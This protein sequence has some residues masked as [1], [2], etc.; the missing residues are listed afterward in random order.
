MSPAGNNIVQIRSSRQ[1]LTNKLL[2]NPIR[3]TPFLRRTL[4]G[5]V[6]YGCA[7]AVATA[8]NGLQ[9]TGFG[10]ESQ[11]MGGADAAVARDSLAGNTNPAGLQHTDQQALDV[12]LSPFVS[13][14]TRHQDALGN[15]DTISNPAGFLGGI[16]YAQRL[17]PQFVTGAGI[18]V[19]GGTG[20]TYKDLDTGFGTTDELSAQFAV[21]KLATAAA[22]RA[23]ERL[24]LGV[25]LGFSYGQARQ[26]VFP[27]TSNKDVPFFG[28]RLDGTSAF[29]IN[30]KLGM[31]YR[32]SPALT[33]GLVY[34]SKSPMKLEHGTLDA[35][36]TDAGLGIVRY[37]EA[38][39]DGLAF[40]QQVEAGVA[41]CPASAWLISLE[42][43]WI[44]W[45][46]SMKSVRLE[47]T[48]PDNP[49]APA[50]FGYSSPLEWRDQY[51]ISL[52][53]EYQVNDRARL[54]FGYSHARQP[55]PD[56]NQN[57]I[58][59]VI[60]E[61]QLAAGLAYRL[62]PEWGLSLGL[63]YQPYREHHYTNPAL[64]VGTDATETNE[65]LWLHLM[66]SRRWGS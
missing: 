53:V 21:L 6:L 2:R 11:G 52:G 32:A 1:Q 27:D 66:L 17:S 62:D 51:P 23:T 61:N 36:F 33:L 31:Q 9:P 24:D 38:G 5:A 14:G 45:S 20:F 25:A 63:E 16:G 26:K 56:Q 35:N 41:W 42:L 55:A 8:G 19:Q 40:A 34:T 30:A 29:D 3:Q 13:I 46:E 49:A 60:A 12:Y 28:Y 58:F 54:R 4:W 7:I 64:S 47:A 59:A 22:W 15:N 48:E 39:L 44:D 50:T 37:R 18:F 57:P 10:A 43:Q 65:Y